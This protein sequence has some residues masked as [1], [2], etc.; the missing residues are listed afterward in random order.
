MRR[1]VLEIFI[2]IQ[3]TMHHLWVVN[4]LTNEEKY[5]YGGSYAVKRHNDPFR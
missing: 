2:K 1:C 5:S 4:I 3:Q